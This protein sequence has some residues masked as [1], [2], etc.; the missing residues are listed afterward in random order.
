MKADDPM[1]GCPCQDA[2]IAR[3]LDG[4]SCPPADVPNEL[5]DL[6]LQDC[7]AC[8]QGLERARL[9]DALVA[10]TGG[11]PATGEDQ[12]TAWLSAAV[13]SAPVATPPAVENP[14]VPPAAAGP[15]L[16]TPARVAVGVLVLLA[17]LV[18]VANGYA[19]FEA[20]GAADSAPPP[21][22]APVDTATPAHSAPPLQPV[23]TATPGPAAAGPAAA[24]VV[25]PDVAA[26]PPGRART[27]PRRRLDLPRLDTRR[28]LDTPETRTAA[29]QLRIDFPTVTSA[30]HLARILSQS[31]LEQQACACLLGEAS[32]AGDG[33]RIDLHSALLA[34]TWRAL[35]GQALRQL[36]AAVAVEAILEQLQLPDSPVAGLEEAALLAALSARG[37]DAAAILKGRLR[38]GN[39]ETALAAAP[40]ALRLDVQTFRTDVLA[41]WSRSQFTPA[42]GRVLEQELQERPGDA[43]FALA[44]QAAL[45][46]GTGVTPHE[47]H[48]RWFRAAPSRLVAQ[49]ARRAEQTPLVQERILTLRVLGMSGD[50]AW[51]PALRLAAESRHMDERLAGHLALRDLGTRAATAALIELAERSRHPWTAVASLITSP[52]DALRNEGLARA[53]AGIPFWPGGRAGPDAV[54]SLELQLGR[55][56][57][58]GP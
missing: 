45:A 26:E 4:D 11:A 37:E 24:M 17:A 53:P 1:P 55:L 32:Y 41:L 54:A 29:L 34:A 42:L 40:I 15:R 30:A 48:V 33:A 57:R 58:R 27:T 50:D 56:A 14:T 2:V 8:R 52:A 23:M 18:V 7:P 43:A 16:L 12:V 49:A 51:L 35:A 6:H 13:E 31:D 36:P 3:F 5:L 38:N 47:D 39:V 10:S 28:A 21:G 44:F 25:L 20:P 19:L 9:L 22:T 46:A